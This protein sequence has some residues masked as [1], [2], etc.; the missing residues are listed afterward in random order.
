MMYHS[1]PYC[2]VIIT[3]AIYYKSESK[4]F[5]RMHRMERQT[6]TLQIHKCSS[7]IQYFN[8]YV[9]HRHQSPDY[10]HY[11]VLLSI[12]SLHINSSKL[13][14]KKAIAMMDCIVFKKYSQILI[15]RVY[16]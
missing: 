5:D 12:V 6:F 8:I 13:N 10:N 11:A 1:R 9:T 7:Y 14:T 16:N 15:Y 2:D 3:N 4:Q